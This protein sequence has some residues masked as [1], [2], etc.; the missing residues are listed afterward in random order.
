M[1]VP[2]SDGALVPAGRAKVEVAGM[3]R[4]LTELIYPGNIPLN[5]RNHMNPDTEPAYIAFEGDRRIGFGSLRDVARAAREALDRNREASIL[6]F[7]SQS[8]AAVDIDLR[9]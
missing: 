5:L 4:P 1:A 9:G 3:R 2:Q 6:I 8:S 7:E